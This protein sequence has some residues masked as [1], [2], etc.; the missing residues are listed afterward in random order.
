MMKNLSERPLPLSLL[1]QFAPKQYE[2][3]R[4]KQIA[5]NPGAIISDAIDDV[6]RI[7]ATACG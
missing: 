2:K 6:L 7:Y 3:I 5:W 1:S 4:Q